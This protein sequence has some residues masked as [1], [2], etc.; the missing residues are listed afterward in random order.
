VLLVTDVDRTIA[1]EEVRESGEFKVLV[2][3][4]TRHKRR[5]ALVGVSQFVSHSLSLS[6]I[7]VEKKK[8]KRGEERHLGVHATAAV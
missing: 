1:Q 2:S 8:K 6:I 4:E 3:V 5:T 7:D